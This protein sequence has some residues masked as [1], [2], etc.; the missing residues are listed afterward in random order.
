[1]DVLFSFYHFFED[2]FFPAGDVT[3]DEFAQE[4]WLERGVPASKMNN[5]SYFVHLVS[6]YEHRNDPNVLVVCFEDLKEDLEKQVRRVAEFMSTEQVSG[7]MWCHYVLSFSSL[8]TCLL[9]RPPMF[10]GIEP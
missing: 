9:T 6:W 4:F 5:A 8:S 10:L 7:W 2:W 1:M 3:L